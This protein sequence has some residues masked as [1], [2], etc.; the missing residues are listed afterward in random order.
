MSKQ[1]HSESTVEEAKATKYDFPSV[2]MKLMNTTNMTRKQ[3]DKIRKKQEKLDRTLETIGIEENIF[4]EV[5]RDRPME[6]RGLLDRALMKRMTTLSAVGAIQCNQPEPEPEEDEEKKKK[7]KGKK[8]KNAKPE[9]VVEPLIIN[10]ET[11]HDAYHFLKEIYVDKL[12]AKQ[13]KEEEEGLGVKR[14]LSS[15]AV[16]S[17]SMQRRRSLSNNPGLKSPNLSQ[18]RKSISRND[19]LKSPNLNQRRKSIVAVD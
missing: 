12:E 3:K 11:V 18:R 5:Y 17:P 9:E 8:S 7:K 2:P 1:V 14:D 19:N 13:A 15:L 16:K 10:R 4:L 6:L